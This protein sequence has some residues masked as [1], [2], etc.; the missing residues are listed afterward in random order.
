MRNFSKALGLAKVCLGFADGCADIIYN[1]FKTRWPM[2]EV[3]S[4]AVAFGS[5]LAD[6]PELVSEQVD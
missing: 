4:F 5:Y 2:N 1:L 6:R 3:N